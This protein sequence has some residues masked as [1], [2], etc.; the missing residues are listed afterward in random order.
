MA[1]IRS[2][3][4]FTLVSALVVAGL[5]ASWA[6]YY[7]TRSEFSAIFDSQLKHTAMEIVESG[8]IDISRITLVGQSPQL[9]LFVQIYDAHENRIYMSQHR[10]PLPVAEVVGFS[11]VKLESGEEWRQY[12]ST[13]GTRI[14]QVAQPMDVRDKLAVSAAMRIVQPMLVLIPFLAIAIW[15]VIV[16]SLQPLNRTARAV[17][18]RSPSSLEPIE[19]KNLPY[20][21]KSL[22]GA[23]NNLLRRL[24]ES[25][26]AQ[27]RFASD[28]A[29]ELRTPL[30]AIKLQAQLLSRC[31][32]E[33]RAKYA[34]RLQQGVARAT[35]L[36]EQL[37]TIARLD[38][39]NADKP[40]SEVDLAAVAAS[41]VEELSQNAHDKAIT[42]TAR[43]EPLTMMGM[44]DAIHLM[45]V[46]LTDNA[47][48][49]TPE[50]GRIEIGVKQKG[51]NAVITVTD[52]GPGIAPEERER[53]FE[54]FYRALG[55]KVS[56]AG[57]GLAIVSRIV[58]MHGGT[59]RIT[60][61][62]ARLA[63]DGT[64]EGFGAQFVVTLPL[65]PA[66]GLP[67]LS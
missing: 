3:I 56:G 25:L 47:I 41:A 37:L 34:A 12:A 64:G 57:L 7:S 46:N 11:D 65:T 22:V 14:I 33:D 16:Q 27:Q 44:P 51:A 6:T 4:V 53:V 24:S 8:A 43:A 26:S 35:R 20:E 10:T 19:I 31:K 42:L 49:Y 45:V 13:V 50:N 36:V 23:I 1:S 18:M 29:H 9:N 62:F 21:L 55:T 61:G 2:K 67:R 66:R 40:M 15:F 39:E 30:A 52:D 63:H 17:S 38:P 48:R 60:D 54:R 28:A 58:A 32:P 59:I 5:V